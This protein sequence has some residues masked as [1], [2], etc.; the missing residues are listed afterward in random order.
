MPSASKHD[1]SDRMLAHSLMAA[2]DARLYHFSS[3]AHS[4][5]NF[6]VPL[7]GSDSSLRALAWAI[8]L[9]QRMSGVAIHIVSVGQPEKAAAILGRAEETLRVAQLSYT[10]EA[11]SGPVAA[12]IAEH[13]GR[14]GCDAIVM[15][16]RGTSAIESLVLGSIANEVVHRTRLP[17]TLVK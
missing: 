4:M 16:T 13:A 5:R 14:L 3:Q 9:A 12:V 6:L 17:V 7:D 15:G 1:V 2:R 11:L 10:K 8:D